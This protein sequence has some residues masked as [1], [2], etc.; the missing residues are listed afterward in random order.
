MNIYVE[1]CWRVRS[2]VDRPCPGQPVR[3]GAVG[4]VQ[5]EGVRGSGQ[6]PGEVQNIVTDVF[7]SECCVGGG[8]PN[9]GP[10]MGK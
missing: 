7:W 9:G 5:L 10:V 1:L 6:A 2:C 8:G 3:H 4:V